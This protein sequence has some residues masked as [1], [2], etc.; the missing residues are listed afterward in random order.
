M[1][2][3][4]KL[5]VPIKY[6]SNMPGG[7]DHYISNSKG[8]GMPMIGSVPA[9]FNENNKATTN[10]P[11]NPQSAI[12]VNVYLPPTDSG[13]NRPMD[14]ASSSAACALHPVQCPASTTPLTGWRSRR[15]SETV[16]PILVSQSLP[17]EGRKW[18]PQ[19]I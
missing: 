2:Q 19:H 12:P 8:H 5:V 16:R 3:T 1:M 10:R 15:S 4:F 18:T 11:T 14:N 9:V 6:P 17:P 13:W 7:I